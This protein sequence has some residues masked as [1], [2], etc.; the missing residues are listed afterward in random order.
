MLHLKLLQLKMAHLVSSNLAE[1]PL[2]ELSITY[3][4]IFQALHLLSVLVLIFASGLQSLG[5][6]FHMMQ[7]HSPTRHHRHMTGFVKKQ[8]DRIYGPMGE[9]DTKT[10]QD[11]YHMELH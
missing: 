10:L 1:K 11:S 2:Y 3:A 6:Y 7:Y 4:S 8:L 9:W 5:K